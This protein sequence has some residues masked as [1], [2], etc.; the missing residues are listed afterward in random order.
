MNQITCSR[1]YLWNL[2]SFK[3]FRSC[4]FGYCCLFWFGLIIKKLTHNLPFGKE[5][6]TISIAPNES[7]GFITGSNYY[8][9]LD[10]IFQKPMTVLSSKRRWER[11]LGVPWQ[12][13]IPVLLPLCDLGA[14]TTSSYTFISQEFIFSIRLFS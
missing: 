6:T 4:F 11:E 14:Q 3:E 5:S 7:S 8:K 13:P 10:S 2:L 12:F 1:C 9:V